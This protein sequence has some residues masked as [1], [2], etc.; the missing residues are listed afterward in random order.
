[1]VNTCPSKGGSSCPTHQRLQCGNTSPVP[2]SPNY[3]RDARNLDFYVKASNFKM[4]AQ[5]CFKQCISQMKHWDGPNLACG[6]GLGLLHCSMQMK[7]DLGGTQGPQVSY[8][9]AHR[10]EQPSSTLCDDP[11]FNAMLASSSCFVLFFLL[12]AF[13][14]AFLLFSSKLVLLYGIFL[15]QELHLPT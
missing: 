7:G 14:S 11:N 3:L 13:L 2:R 9:M 15:V 4:L 5:K 10:K 1:M 6:R 12:F 8:H